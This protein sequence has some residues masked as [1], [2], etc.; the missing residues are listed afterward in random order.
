V[1]LHL[2][3]VGL[4]SKGLIEISKGLKYCILLEHLDLRKNVFDQKG[5][6]AIINALMETMSIRHLYL[7]GT[8]I[9]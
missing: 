4:D 8:P 3:D 5:L 6:E 1:E 7:E 2:I 9:D